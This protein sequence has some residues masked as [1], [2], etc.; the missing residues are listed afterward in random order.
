MDTSPIVHEISLTCSP[1]RAFQ[2]FTEEVGSW[3][4]PEYTANPLTYATITIDPRMRGQITERH[5]DG[6]EHDWGQV[7]GWEPPTRV[8]FSFTLSQD[9][10]FPTVVRATFEPSD[11]GTRLIFEHDGWTKFNADARAKFTAWP[12]LLARY[13]DAANAQSPP[14]PTK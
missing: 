10:A 9:R 3:W 2:V 8:A 13:A 11:Q 6:S 14:E 4:D 12:H 5:I 7:L 1:E